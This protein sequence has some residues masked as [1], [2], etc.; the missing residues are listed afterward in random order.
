MKRLQL[1]AT[2]VGGIA[3]EAHTTAMGASMNLEFVFDQGP[4]TGQSFPGNLEFQ[5]GDGLKYPDDGSLLD[6]DATID[7]VNFRMSDDVDFPD[8]PEAEISAGSLTYLDGVFFSNNAFFDITYERGI[9]NEVTFESPAG[10]ISYGFLRV[11]GATIPDTG[12]TWAMCGAGLLGLAWGRQR[13]V[14]QR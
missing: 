1:L 11:S 13:L 10:D 7:A 9:G 6:F 14:V 2:L 5:P 12:A 4:L 3:L 8:F